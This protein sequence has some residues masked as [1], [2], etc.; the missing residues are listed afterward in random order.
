MEPG[1]LIFTTERDESFE[2]PQLESDRFWYKVLLVRSFRQGIGE[3]FE[4][5]LR[6]GKRFTGQPASFRAPWLMLRAVDGPLPGWV[7]FLNVSEIEAIGL[8]WTLEFARYFLPRS[9]RKAC[10]AVGKLQ[11]SKYLQTLSATVPSELKVSVSLDGDWNA[12]TEEDCLILEDHL[13][14]LIQGLLALKEQF[15][16]SVA[17]VT[18]FA[19]GK[20]AGEALTLSARNGTVA[21]A[22][23]FESDSIF[24]SIQDLSTQLNNVL[25][26]L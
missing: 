20:P 15:P 16:E 19:F 26:N 8:A 12:I 18:S 7:T 1:K 4:L 3:H 17:K 9:K 21:A 2:L 6:D 22:L 13:A 14:V 5:H 10:P 24:N 23:P 11:L 25:S